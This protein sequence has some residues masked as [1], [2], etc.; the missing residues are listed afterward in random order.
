MLQHAALVLEPLLL[1]GDLLQAAL[2]GAMEQ[3][4]H[5]EVVSLDRRLPEAREDEHS[6]GEAVQH[7][8]VT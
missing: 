6:D 8:A 1:A 7:E 3:S 2:L 5:G 4:P